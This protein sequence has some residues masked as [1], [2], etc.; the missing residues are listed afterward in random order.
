[1]SYIVYTTPIPAVYDLCLREATT[2]MEHPAGV[3]SNGNLFYDRYE[4]Q[5]ASSWKAEQVYRRYAGEAP[6]NH[7]VLCYDNCIVILQPNW[8]LTREQMAIVGN[9]F[10]K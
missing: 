8:E 6:Y 1:M 2:P 9:T 4:Q 3:D 10:G 5:E 7:Y